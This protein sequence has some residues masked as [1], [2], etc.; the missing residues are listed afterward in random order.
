MEMVWYG[1]SVGNS[2][3]ENFSDFSLI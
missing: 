2:F 1:Y 3:K